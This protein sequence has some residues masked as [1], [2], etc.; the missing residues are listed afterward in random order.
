MA[1]NNGKIRG[2]QASGIFALFVLAAVA[3]WQIAGGA[4]PVAAQAKT[5]VN[6]KDGL[7]YVFVPPGTF[8]MGCSP[9]DAECSDEEK[10][11]HSVT[12]TQG[13]WIGQTPVTG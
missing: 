1:E 9:G 4:A 10:P 11:A 2:R 13:F 12:I 3:A 8:Q 6:P 5:K 7:T